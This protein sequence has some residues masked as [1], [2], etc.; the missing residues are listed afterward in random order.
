MAMG[1]D[2]WIDLQLH[3][4][5]IADNN[6]AIRLAPLRTLHMSSKEFLEE[7][8]DGQMIRQ[9]AAGKRPDAR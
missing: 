2:R 9:I 1:V 6:I 3:P 5:K 4:D 7:F 8:P